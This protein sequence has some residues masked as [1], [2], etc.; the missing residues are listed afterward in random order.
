MPEA[1]L[2]VNSLMRCY[3]VTPMAEL[4]C[5]YSMFDVPTADE[6]CISY[7]LDQSKLEFRRQIETFGG[8]LSVPRLCYITF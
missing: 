6:L 5:T 1:G 7:W 4:L 8:L 3:E 2:G